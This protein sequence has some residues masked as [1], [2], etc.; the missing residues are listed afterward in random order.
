M[1]EESR[2][3]VA[4]AGGGLAGLCLA[5]EIRRAAP[6]ARILVVERNPHPVADTAHKV[7]ESSVEVASH[8]FQQVLG[9]GELLAREV[10]KFGLRFFMSQG[11][12]SSVQGASAYLWF[13]YS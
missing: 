2:Y 8:Y 1:S 9:L 4:I 12:G 5:L 11:E 6:R 13:Q 10:P 7:G 3:D